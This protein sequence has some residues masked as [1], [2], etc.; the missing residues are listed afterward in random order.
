MPVVPYISALQDHCYIK[1]LLQL[2]KGVSLDAYF[3]LEFILLPNKSEKTI[4]KYH[5]EQT[6]SIFSGVCCR[7]VSFKKC[8]TMNCDKVLVFKHHT[9]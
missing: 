8:A 4:F 1:K 7:L 6:G 5:C 2:L 3:L 9:M